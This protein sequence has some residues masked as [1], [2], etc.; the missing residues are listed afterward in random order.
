MI[1]GGALPSWPRHGNWSDCGRHDFLLLE[2]EQETGGNAA[3]GRN[4][5]SAYPWGA[6]YVPLPNEESAEVLELFEELGITRGRDASGAPIYREEYLCADPM[7]RL[8][9]AGRWQEGLLPQ[10]GIT[11]NV[12][13]KSTARMET[14][15]RARHR[16]APAFAIPLDLR[17]VIRRCSR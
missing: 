6:H 17:R 12:A 13:T 16:R 4:A 1:V 3:C 10:I 5:I 14:F 15:K 2:L 11:E 7:E 9:D 8:F